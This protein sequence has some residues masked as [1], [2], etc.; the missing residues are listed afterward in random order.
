M[1]PG[2]SSSRLFSKCAQSTMSR[3]S[4]LTPCS[5][6]RGP[7]QYPRLHEGW[8]RSERVKF[9]LAATS[10]ERIAAAA[11]VQPKRNGTEHQLT[12][13]GIEQVTPIAF[14]Q[15]VGAV[16]EHDEARRPSLH[17]R[18]VAKLDPLTFR[19]RWRIGVDGAFEPA[20]ELPGRNA[21]APR[22]A[23]LQ[24]D[25]QDRLDTLAGFRRNGE[26]RNVTQLRQPFRERG[27]DAV[28]QGGCVFR[29][30]PF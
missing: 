19:S 25:L 24:R 5:S 16:A 10:V 2:P 27:L 29:H 12:A 18:D 4:S 14:G 1:K 3:A 22:V 21:L 23:Q 28:E 7:K 20:V 30:V 9:A 8:H 17:L 26:Q 11:E 15:F 13:E 6:R